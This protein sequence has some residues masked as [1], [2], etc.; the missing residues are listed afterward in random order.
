MRPFFFLIIFSLLYSSAYAEKM[1]TRIVNVEPSDDGLH[2]HLLLLE[3]GRVATVKTD[4]KKALELYRSSNDW[5]EIEVNKKNELIGISTIPAPV[6]AVEDEAFLENEKL[7]KSEYNPTH[8][9]SMSEAQTIFGRMNRQ[10]QRQ[11]QC[12]NRAH[13]WAYEEFKRSG[14]QSIKL[15]MFF[16]KRYIWDYNYGWWF[17]VTPMTYVA[18]QAVTL[19]RTFTRSPLSVKN[20]TLNF[21]RSRRD[22]PMVTKYSD[23]SQHQET[24]HCYLIPATMYFW[25]PR[26]LDQFERTGAQKTEFIKSEVNYAYWEAF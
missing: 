14:L 13:V 1:K 17:H 6:K 15:F 20:W 9:S 10:H 24:E 16:T 22:C 8:L 26:D 7:P 3:N 19:D 2:P 11:S 18:D 21:I 5:L 4:E 25:Q 23:Y 12:Y